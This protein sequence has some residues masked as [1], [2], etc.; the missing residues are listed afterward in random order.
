[1]L[2]VAES[3][4]LLRYL[5]QALSDLDQGEVHA[6]SLLKTLLFLPIVGLKRPY[7]LRDYSGD[8]L[9]LLSGRTPHYSY[10]HVERFLTDLTHRQGTEAITMAVGNWIGEMWSHD[11]QTIYYVDGHHKPVYSDVRIP[12]GLIGRTGKVLGSRALT[13]LHDD[14]GHPLLVRTDR[15]D[16]HLT[17]S[18]PQILAD[19]ADHQPFDEK[20]AIVVDRECMAT[21]FLHDYAPTYTIIT[22]LKSNQYQDLSSFQSVSEFVPLQYDEM[23]LLTQELASAIFELVSPTHNKSLLLSVALIRDHRRL[24]TID[25][26]SQQVEAHW[27]Q[28]RSQWMDL[29]WKATPVPAG[30]TSPKLIPIVCTRPNVDPQQLVNWYRQRWHV[31]E[32]VIKDFLLPLGIDTNHGY[33]KI[34]V[35]NSELAK[36]HDTLTRRLTRLERW[37]CAA[38]KR[39]QRASK[40]ACLLQKQL[41]DLINHHEVYYNQQLTHDLQPPT[42]PDQLDLETY[43]QQQYQRIR[44]LMNK[45]DSDFNKANHYARQ[46]CHTQRDLINLDQRTQPMFELDNL[47]DQLMSALKLALTNL[48][49]WARQHLFPDS[50]NQATWN[51]LHPFFKLPGRL[52]LLPDRCCVYLKPFHPLDLQRDLEHLCH[53]INEAQLSL[54]DGRILECYMERNL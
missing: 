19:Y 51:R 8:G 45:S 22:L 10:V 31:Q 4:G 41:H 46:L 34:P 26:S 53:N 50:Y 21:D 43:Q 47:K 7:D 13:L 17:D 30:T 52:Q 36:P 54:P 20:P 25:P 11:D 24:Q 6:H 18:L 33:A 32:N 39:S 1:M 48:A 44:T 28:H 2:A 29:E 9:G 14:A 27:Q 12:R 37:R 42:I 49:M 3:S 15:G 35:K 38:L 5:R 16:C 40:Q 23:G